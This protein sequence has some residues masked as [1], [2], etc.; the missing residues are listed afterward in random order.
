M[1][2]ITGTANKIIDKVLRGV[3][4]TAATVWYVSLHTAL[5]GDTG[6]SEVTGGS[7]ARQSVTFNAAG[8]KATT[9]AAV[10]TFATMPA[11]TVTHIGIWGASSAG[12]IWWQGALSA[13][14]TVGAGDTFQIAAGDLDIA[15]A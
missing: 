7:Y 9:N 10:L 12:T 1:A 2:F 8:T 14:K 6:T 4:F 3:D 5:P 15:L 13:P 11:A